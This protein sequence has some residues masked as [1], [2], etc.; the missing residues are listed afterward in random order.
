MGSTRRLLPMRTTSRLVRDPTIFG[1]TAIG[2]RTTGGI[3]GLP[4]IGI[5]S[6][7]ASRRTLIAGPTI[8]I[9]GEALLAASTKRETAVLARVETAM[10]RTAT[11][12]VDSTKA[13]RAILGRIKPRIRTVEI[14]TGPAKIR[15]VKAAAKKAVLQTDSEAA[16]RR[17]YEHPLD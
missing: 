15:V 7:S 12:P 13:R 2:R 11:K 17:I 4:D 1:S 16:S 8:A 3:L 10:G 6:N 5:G 9:T 14:P